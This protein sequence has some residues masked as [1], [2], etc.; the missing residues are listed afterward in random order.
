VLITGCGDVGLRLLRQLVSKPAGIRVIASARRAEQ[1]AEI[2]RLGGV[3]IRADL[4]ERRSL[5]RL[6]A[7]GTHVVH[8]APPPAGGSGDPRTRRLIAALSRGPKPRGRRR[9]AYVSTTGVYGDCAGAQIDETRPCRPDSERARRRVIAESMLRAVSRRTTARTAI[10][11]A[12]GIYAAD[13]LPLERLRSGM[14]AL[15]PAEDVWT[16][17]IHAEDLARACWLA[18]ARGRP[19]RAINVVDQSELRMGD[20][21]DQVADAFGLPR[22]PRLPRAELARQVSPMMLS[23]MSESRQIGNLRMRKELRLRL[24][25]PTVASQLALLT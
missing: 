15:S 10:L 16:N 5:R 25:F 24:A 13:R 2:R 8:L 17:H 1:L 6:A 18:L 23:F 7:F 20:Y 22:P 3:P 9:W 4:D 19:G 12:P 21:F 14:P 11:R